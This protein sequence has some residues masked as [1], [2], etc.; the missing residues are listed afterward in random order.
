MKKVMD[1]SVHQ[2]AMNQSK[3]YDSDGVEISMTKSK[4]VEPIIEF[5]R[6]SRF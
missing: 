5:K 4:G 2:M 6:H 3:A 1:P